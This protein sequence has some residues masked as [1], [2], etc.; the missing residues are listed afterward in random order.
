MINWTILLAVET[1]EAATKSGGLFDL[2]ATLPLMAVQFLILAFI[3]NQIFYKP[4]GKAIDERGEYIRSN[5]AEAQERLAKAERLAQQYEHELAMARKD[6]Q[7]VIAAAQAEAQK[8]VAT[9]MAEAQAEVQAK[10]EQAQQEIEQQKQETLRSLE[11]QVDELSQ[12]IINKLLR[13]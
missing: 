13:V 2:D 4:I 5:Q 8:I 9:K 11:Q 10:R 7:T 6:S 12:Q 3:L 1:A